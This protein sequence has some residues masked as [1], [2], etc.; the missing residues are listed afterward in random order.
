MLF[1]GGPV[2]VDELRNDLR[3][4]RVIVLVGSGVSIASTGSAPTS[5]WT[6]L[7][8]NGL[9]R[10][11]AITKPPAGFRANVEADIEFARVSGTTTPL[12]AAAEKVTRSL[13]AVDGAYEDWLRDA[14]GSLR[15]SSPGLIE[16]IGL[17][18]Q[19]ILTTN[20][21]NL[22]EEVLRRDRVT[23][24]EASQIHAAVLAKTTD[25]GHI[26]GHW[27]DP[28]SV[29]FSA[30][31]YG[32]QGSN[33]AIQALQQAIALTRKLLFVGCGDGTDD[34][35]I[36]ALLDWASS[37]VPSDQSK[38]Y[39]LCT[40]AESEGL[41]Q[42]GPLIPIAYGAAYADL[43]SFLSSL[44]TPGWGGMSLARP[45]Q[46]TIESLEERIRSD[47]VLAD[48]LVDIER[49]T[50]NEL[51]V[52][53]V[54][55]PVPH[56]QYVKAHKE[57]IAEPAAIKRCDPAEEVYREQPLIL[58]ADP[59]AGLTGA[60]TWIIG[61]RAEREPALT[62]LIIDFR[63][64]TSGSHPLDRQIRKELRL[65]G[66]PIHP[67]EP[68][69]PIALAIDNVQPRPEKILAAT[70]ADVAALQPKMVIFGCRTGNEAE[71]REALTSAF[72][73]P[74]IRYIGRFDRIDARRLAAL[75][76]PSRAVAIGARAFAIVQSEHLA[77]T[78]LTFGLLTSLLLRGEAYLA[79]GSETALLDA[80]VSLLLGRGDP[81]DDARITLDAMDREAVLATLAE[82]FVDLRSGALEE[83]VAI[84]TLASMF[85]DVGWNDDPITVLNNLCDRHILAIS[86]GRVRFAQSSYLHLF[87]AKRAV[88]SPEF[89]ASLLDEMV[90]Y[91]PIIKHY[92]SL[93]RN[94]AQLL[95]NILH[96]LEPVEERRSTAMSFSV[97]ESPPDTVPDSLDKIVERLEN[98]SPNDG[99]QQARQEDDGGE[100]HAWRDLIAEDDAEPFPLDRLQDS[101]QIFR[102]LNAIGLASNVLRSSELVRDRQLKAEVLARLLEV[103]ADFVALL[104]VDEEY[105]QFSARLAEDIADMFDA[106]N[107]SAR[108]AFVED[109]QLMSPL[110]LVYGGIMGSLSSRKLS[111]ALASCFDEAAFA[112]DC[113]ASVVGALLASATA[114]PGWGGQLAR[115]GSRHPHVLGVRLVLK[116]LALV[117]YYS[118]D[119]S[120][121]DRELLHDFLVDQEM[122]EG[123]QESD[124]ER[125]SV[126]ARISR[127][128]EVGRMKA[129]KSA[130]AKNRLVA[131]GD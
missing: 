61:S 54:L 83:A 44:I 94:N 125:K 66:I 7:I 15:V 46:R 75:A 119:T 48:S 29:V 115:V 24:R 16:A 26:H 81:H 52:P 35:N 106:K 70:I 122:L 76:E 129:L 86:N 77:A 55:L 19:P 71:L 126:R 65:L 8:R 32:A 87:A 80:Y 11:E 105:R 111:I 5:S 107:A 6:G 128:Y 34:P 93:T 130:D 118:A 4:Q 103:W 22:L 73:E 123:P 42:S 88:E 72:A 64:L 31:M 38:H 85:N 100:V 56:D 79:T 89:L 110:F 53:P 3:D 114:D 17:L 28:A 102:V 50:L 43:T 127:A 101:G 69:P 92:A 36:G 131:A 104:E 51:L 112:Q 82:T 113:G 49:R 67:A 78:P 96:M 39:R 40:S 63:S 74:D 99:R 20:Y 2:H 108:E 12:I 57:E 47:S 58:A 124:A 97:Y 59:M 95:K 37:I 1:L 23:W 21:D 14:I 13:Q 62:P 41:D 9:D 117:G 90:Y 30:Q 120:G 10:V 33:D 84:A 27:R 18:G 45:Q 116:M 121:A 91:A 98:F 68:L 25:I 60:L 109:F